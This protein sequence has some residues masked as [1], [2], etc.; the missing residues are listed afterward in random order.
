MNR[1]DKMRLCLYIFSKIPKRKNSTASSNL[2]NKMKVPSVSGGGGVGGGV[3]A[4][5]KSGMVSKR[6]TS[7]N[8]NQSSK[9]A[10]EPQTK[11]YNHSQLQSLSSSLSPPNAIVSMAISEKNQKTRRLLDFIQKQKSMAK[12]AR[13]TTAFNDND[14]NGQTYS[15]QQQP[16]KAINGHHQRDA[17]A[18]NGYDEHHYQQQQ[19]QQQQYE[20]RKK[21]QI[22][23]MKSRDDDK[24][25]PHPFVPSKRIIQHHDYQNLVD[26]TKTAS[27]PSITSKNQ[28]PIQN[29][30]SNQNRTR[31]DNGTYDS[32]INTKCNVDKNNNR[33]QHN[34]CNEKP[35]QQRSKTPIYR[36]F[37]DTN[38]LRSKGKQSAVYYDGM[39]N[40]SSSNCGSNISLATTEPSMATFDKRT[41]YPETKRINATDI[42]R[43]LRADVFSVVS[44][45]YVTSNSTNDT[46]FGSSLDT[47]APS[48]V[49]HKPK[50]KSNNSKSSNFHLP[51]HCINYNV[52][53]RIKLFDVDPSSYHK[54]AAVVNKIHDKR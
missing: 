29:L 49:M 39:N 33:K 20:R 19:Q 35:K 9:V 21:A 10:I 44:T 54:H 48:I 5:S 23:S 41:A 25:A 47:D 3:G 36:H 1:N 18:R 50:S 12:D 13:T 8:R 32:V 16:P 22:E 30:Q 7:S 40:N 37:G 11:L 28:I 4:S 27:S 31:Y 2:A 24:A 42:N 52:K 26:D 14:K 34:E 53:N 15:P 51:F 46:G 38:L 45:P 43:N 17:S 6:C